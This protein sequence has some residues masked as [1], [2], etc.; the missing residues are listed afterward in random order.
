[1]GEKFWGEWLLPLTKPNN[2]SCIWGRYGHGE[3]KERGDFE[4]SGLFPTTGGGSTTNISFL[5]LS[6]L[7][8]IPGKIVSGLLLYPTTV[9]S[10]KSEAYISLVRSLEVLTF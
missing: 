1:M 2:L 3:R 9:Y 6:G 4:Y 10:L 7:S 8:F 5:P